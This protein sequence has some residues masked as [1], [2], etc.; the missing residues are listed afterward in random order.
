M[1][2]LTLK[3]Y[4]DNADSTFDMYSSLQTP[5]VKYC[6]VAFRPGSEILDIGSGS[7][8]DLDY[9][10]SEGYEA[11]GAEPSSK[12]RAVSLAKFP[13][14]QGRI[15]TA[16]LPDLAPKI[17]KKFDGILCSAVFQHI[18]QGQQS[19]TALDIRNL[20]KP[21]GRLLLF[22]PKDRPGLDASNRDE[23][24][25]LYTKL[26]AEEMILLFKRLGF[27]CIGNWNELEDGLGRPGFTWQ[28]LLLH[29][30]EQ[31]Y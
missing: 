29:L 3:Y 4:D 22:F 30:L 28:T 23:G 17:G 31:H 2:A 24:G 20:L 19:D 6:P 1:D 14:L 7:S 27:E 18:P 5:L 8:R 9:L 26:G 12:L 13:H 21:N 10:I 25:R 15:F 16:G 11:W